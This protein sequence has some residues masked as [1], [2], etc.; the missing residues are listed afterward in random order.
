MA[1]LAAAAAVTERIELAC[2]VLIGP[3]RSE[4]LLLKQATTLDRLAGGRFTLGLGVGPREDDYRRAG[5]D[6]RGR[7]RAL[8]LQVAALAEARPERGLA[9]GGSS[10]Q[11]YLRAARHAS[12]FVHGGGPPRGFRAAAD[13]A[14]AA[15]S[16]L[17]RA[18]RPRLWG[19][20]YFA[21]G[22]GARE[23][24]MAD[25]LRYYAFTGSLAERVATGSLVADEAELKAYV[26]GYRANGCDDLV[27]F[28]TIAELDQLE[29]LAALLT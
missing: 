15:W 14:L 25:L 20:G 18:G 10:D 11:A 1:T 4:A 3:L 22:P 23:R 6:W 27:L 24:G 8:D 28:P 21:L 16:D 5:A 7:G 17:G 9:V 2:L 29:R 13:R 12:G 26:E 19:T